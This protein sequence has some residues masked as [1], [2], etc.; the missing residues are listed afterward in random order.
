MANFLQA[1]ALAA[2]AAEACAAEFSHRVHIALKLECVTCHVSAAASRR[3]EDN[4]LPPREVCLKCHQDAT[5]KQPR[6]TALA[7]FSHQQHV[8]VRPCAGCHRGI[9]TSEVTSKAN[10]PP[11]AD[12]VVCHNRVEIPNSC[13]MCH[14]KTMRL[15]PESHVPDFIDSHSR[16]KHSAEE[17][18][19]CEVCHGRNFTCAGCH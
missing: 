4:N 6:P 3:V 13:W 12:C 10:F 17:K 1:L 15:T 8:R 2:L 18:R 9:E 5:I 16:V 19:S 7:H 14:A 11:M